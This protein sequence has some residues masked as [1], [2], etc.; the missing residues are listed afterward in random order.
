[1]ERVSVPGAQLG[2]DAMGPGAGQRRKDKEDA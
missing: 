1:M 2:A